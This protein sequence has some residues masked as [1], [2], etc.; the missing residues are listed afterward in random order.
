MVN[1]LL[2][3]VIANPKSEHHWLVLA[4]YVTEHNEL[5]GEALN[6]EVRFQFKYGNYSIASRDK[7]FVALYD[8][9][10]ALA[11]EHHELSISIWNLVYFHRCKTIDIEQWKQLFDFIINHKG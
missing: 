3:S 5:A 11:R 9:R 7:D 2:D 1:E 4:D 8:Q 6:I 10:W